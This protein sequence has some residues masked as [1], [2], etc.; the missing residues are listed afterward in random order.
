MMKKLNSSGVQVHNFDMN[1]DS[2][3]AIGIKVGFTI[4]E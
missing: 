2:G 4:P 1:N 3:K